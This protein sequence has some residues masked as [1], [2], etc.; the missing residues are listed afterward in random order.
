M[1]GVAETIGAM[2]PAALPESAGIKPAGASGGGLLP[3]PWFTDSKQAGTFIKQSSPR[4][5]FGRMADF[6]CELVRFTRGR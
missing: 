4:Q 3:R 1:T 2:R 6:D 5:S